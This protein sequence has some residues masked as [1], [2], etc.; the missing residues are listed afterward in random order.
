M[1]AV[2]RRRFEVIDESHA[3][4]RPIG[5]RGWDVPLLART[6]A[7]ARLKRAAAHARRLDVEARAVLL[8]GAPVR[9][10]AREAVRPG[11]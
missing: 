7:L 6:Q 11:R 3:I 9:S 2:N 10:L 1:A 8:V 4:M 5:G